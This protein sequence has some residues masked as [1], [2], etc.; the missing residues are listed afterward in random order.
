MASRALTEGAL[1]GLFE[2]ERYRDAG[3]H[4]QDDMVLRRL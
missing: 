2:L 3:Y 1:K 4:Q